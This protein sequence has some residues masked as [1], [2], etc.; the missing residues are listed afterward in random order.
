IEVMPDPFGD[1]DSFVPPDTFIEKIELIYFVTDPTYYDDTLD[2]EQV[3][4][5]L[6]PVWHYYGH[7]EDGNEEH[8]YI[9]ALRQEYLLPESNP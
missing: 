3:K 7:D 5:Y 8:T 2:P 4:L 9:Q 6:Q 1:A